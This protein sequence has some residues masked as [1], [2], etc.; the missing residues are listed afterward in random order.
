MLSVKNATLNKASLSLSLSLKKSS[1]I[2]SGVEPW[3]ST[4]KLPYTQRTTFQDFNCVNC[5]EKVR[6]RARGVRKMHFCTIGR[7]PAHAH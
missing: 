6:V 4:L 2:S 1:K 3:V 5:F 7:V